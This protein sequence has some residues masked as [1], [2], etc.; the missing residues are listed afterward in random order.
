MS[1]SVGR[2]FIPLVK[3]KNE[4][5]FLSYDFLVKSFGCIFGKSTVDDYDDW[6]EWS[7]QSNDLRNVLRD[8]TSVHDN[9]TMGYKGTGFIFSSDEKSLDIMESVFSRFLL[10]RTD[11]KF[12]RFVPLDICFSKN[13]VSYISFTGNYGFIKVEQVLQ[14]RYIFLGNFS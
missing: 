2:F 3:F 5:Y 1:S 8:Y 11:L 13:P 7:Y 6:Y 10:K 12:H 9:L 14:S 4:K